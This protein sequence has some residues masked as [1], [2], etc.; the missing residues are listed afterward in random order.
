MPLVAQLSAGDIIGATTL[1][2]TLWLASMA[3]MWKI[4][5]LLSG[6]TSELRALKDETETTKVQG[7]LNAA[8]IVQIQRRFDIPQAEAPI[9]QVSGNEQVAGGSG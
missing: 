2:L 1:A 3:A 6:I 8:N 7:Q 9:D 4:A 5:T